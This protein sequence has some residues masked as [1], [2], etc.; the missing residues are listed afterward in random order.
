[1]INRPISL[2][3]FSNKQVV[4][5]HEC[6]DSATNSES[7][8]CWRPVS[9]KQFYTGKCHA[10]RECGPILANVGGGRT[11]PGNERFSPI[12]P[13]E[14]TDFASLWTRN[15]HGKESGAGANSLLLDWNLPQ[16]DWASRSAWTHPLY[17]LA[18]AILQSR[19]R[20][21]RRQR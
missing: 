19:H 14:P 2:M 21:Q 7:R 16:R 15:D 10:G 9:R 1:M 3:L 12:Q 13:I 8:W 17:R 11:L 6:L 4:Q 20:A 18:S 5:F